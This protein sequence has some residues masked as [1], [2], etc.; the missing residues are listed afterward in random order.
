M[1]NRFLALTVIILV[2]CLSV[3]ARAVIETARID[4]KIQKAADYFLNRK[5]EEDCKKG[6]GLLVEAMLLAA[7]ETGF[8]AEFAAKL[9][10]ANSLFANTSILNPDG[11]VLFKQ[12]YV[13]INS[14]KDYQFPQSV[15]NMKQALEYLRVNVAA[16][17]KE[18]SLGKA[19]ACVKTILEVALMIVTPMEATS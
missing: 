15:S 5:S 8:P 11:I 9:T 3:R 1:K 4:A 18:L 10:E 6:F 12:A 16:A 19:D 14:G 2:A 7:P 13:L 17:R